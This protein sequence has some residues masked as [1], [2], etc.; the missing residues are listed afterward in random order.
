MKEK[1]NSKYLL[2]FR[3]SSCSKIQL[4]TLYSANLANSSFQTFGKLLSIKRIEKN[5]PYE[6]DSLTHTSVAIRDAFWYCNI[7]PFAIWSRNLLWLL[8]A[9]SFNLSVNSILAAFRGHSGKKV[10]NHMISLRMQSEIFL[11]QLL[12]PYDCRQYVSYHRTIP[13]NNNQWTTS[14][15]PQT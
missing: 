8:T 9:N 2:V 11:I 14:P 12:P 4:R 3:H 7:W 1:K 13:L 6:N 10:W 5:V 15:L